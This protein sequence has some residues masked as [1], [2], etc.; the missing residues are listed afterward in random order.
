MQNLGSMS[1]LS[2]AHFFHKFAIHEAVAVAS[3]ASCLISAD[4]AY[5][6]Q[7]LYTDDATILP[8]GACQVEAFSKRLLDRG[9]AGAEAAVQPACNLGGN[10]EWSLAYTRVNSSDESKLHLIGIGAKTVFRTLET[11][12]WGA[13][14]SIGVTSDVSHRIRSQSAG[15]NFLYSNAPNDLVLFHLNVGATR[16]SGN[17]TMGTWSTAL[18]YNLNERSA[19]S[20]ERYGEQHQRPYWRVGGRTALVA[21]RFQVEAALENQSGAGRKSMILFLGFTLFWMNALGQ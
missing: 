21:D 9:R 2:A 8:Q 16:K 3:L 1:Q 15:V 10:A 12:G 11:G 18:E 6:G 5:A 19:L 7:P 17:R 13:G 4:P 20:V 14:A